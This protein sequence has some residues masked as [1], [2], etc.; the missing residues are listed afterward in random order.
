MTC[1][2]KFNV[3]KVV[4]HGGDY[5]EVHMSA[6]YDDGISKENKSFAVT[7]PSGTLTFSLT[8]PALTDAFK[9]GQKYYLQFVNADKGAA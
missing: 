6:V 9:P 2:A 4:H 7:T 5:R 3:D 1:V 8:N